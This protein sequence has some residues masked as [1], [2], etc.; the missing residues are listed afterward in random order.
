MPAVDS[1][2]KLLGPSLGSYPR[3]T[4]RDVD[5]VAKAARDPKQ[6]R[7]LHFNRTNSQPKAAMYDILIPAEG[8][9]VQ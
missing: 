9:R 8:I 5:V 7:G 3:Y 1:T 6:K 4:G 2:P